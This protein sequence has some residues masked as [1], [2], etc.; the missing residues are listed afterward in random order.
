MVS[1]CYVPIT[2][3][4]AFGHSLFLTLTLILWGRWF[5]AR[6]TGKKVTLRNWII[7]L[8]AHSSVSGSAMILPETFWICNLSEWSLNFREAYLLILLS[9]RHFV[10]LS[11]KLLI[12]F[13]RVFMPQ[14]HYPAIFTE[15]ICG[16]FLDFTTDPFQ[17]QKSD[18]L[19]SFFIPVLYKFYYTVHGP[20]RNN[21]HL[22]KCSTFW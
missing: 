2:W 17:T 11:L 1:S 3:T 18:F 6:F 5:C 16:T 15:E 8:N 13:E 21:T 22:F 10:F 14:L 19:I 9:C 4:K 12:W 7:Y 20:C